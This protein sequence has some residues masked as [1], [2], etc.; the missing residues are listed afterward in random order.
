MRGK[1]LL[2]GYDH[3]FSQEVALKIDMGYYIKVMLE[4]FPYKIKETQKTPWMEK[5]LKIQKDVKKLNKELRILFHTYVTKGKIL[6]K[7]VRTNI[8]QAISYLS[9]RF[10]DAND[11]YCKKLFP[12]MSFL[13]R[14][15]IDVLMLEADDTNT[16]I[17]CINLS[18]ALLYDMKSH[19]GAVFPMGKGVVINISTKKKVNSR[20]SAWLELI[21]V[22]EKISKVLWMK[23]FLEWQVLPVKLKIIYK[24]NTSR[25][26]QE[27]NGKGSLGK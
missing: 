17:W 23:C 27:E 20:R 19:T 6:C 8:Y 7:I 10:K 4:E 15:I 25:I 14:T 2:S 22:Y 11:V 1:K 12:V 24:D 5:L 21:G 18:L 3:G 9:S 16:L 26:K 13:K